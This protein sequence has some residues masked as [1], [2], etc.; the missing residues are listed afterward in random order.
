MLPRVSTNKKD[1]KLGRKARKDKQDLAAVTGLEERSAQLTAALE[2]KLGKE[3][4]LA[5]QELQNSGALEIAKIQFDPDR[6]ATG[7]KITEL[8]GLFPVMPGKGRGE[9]YNR[10]LKDILANKFSD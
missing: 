10:R 5:V 4:A 2:A 8:Q 9:E 7:R 1:F 3:S 6:T